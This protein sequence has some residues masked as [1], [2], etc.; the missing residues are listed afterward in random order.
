M[1]I[2]IRPKILVV[3]DEIKMLAT[4]MLLL[5]RSGF[6]VSGA[7]TGAEGI[8]LSQKGEFDLVILDMHLPDKSGLEICAW[9][10]EDFRFSRTPIVFTSILWT[11]GERRRAFELGAADCVDKSLEGPAFVQRICRH[12]KVPV[13]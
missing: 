12:L 11:E 1:K 8:R 3:E 6:D 4:M 13:R 7:Q 9:L 10:K 5:D 2:N